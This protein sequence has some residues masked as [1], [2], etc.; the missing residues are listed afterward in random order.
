M[1]GFRHTCHAGG[2]G[3]ESRRSRSTS[4]A[5]IAAFSPLQ[6]ASAGNKRAPWKRLGNVGWQML[7]QACLTATSDPAVHVPEVRPNG[8]LELSGRGLLLGHPIL[9]T[10]PNIGPDPMS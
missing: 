7:I 6:F 9:D 3:F 8:G 2:R 1:K 4:L 10:S 5:Q